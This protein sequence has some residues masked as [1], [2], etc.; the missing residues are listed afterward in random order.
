[1]IGMRSKTHFCENTQFLHWNT[2]S[3]LSSS[4]QTAPRS[5]NRSKNFDWNFSNGDRV[6]QWAIGHIIMSAF[7][8]CPLR[9]RSENL[10]LNSSKSYGLEQFLLSHPPWPNG[11]DIEKFGPD[12]TRSNNL[13]WNSSKSPPLGQGGWLRRN[14]SKPC[15]LEEFKL[16][17]PISPGAGGGHIFKRKQ[18]L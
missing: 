16:D 4:S 1:M 15:D 10:N 17:S 8:L 3:F 14:C 7:F 12:H 6:A 11:V 2:F 9:V 13:N 18:P 5:G